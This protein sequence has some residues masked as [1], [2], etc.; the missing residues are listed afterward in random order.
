MHV[1]HSLEINIQH[2]KQQKK[3]IN[4]QLKTKIRFEKPI[5]EHRP[6][7]KQEHPSLWQSTYTIES[8]V[9]KILSIEIRPYEQFSNQLQAYIFARCSLMCSRRKS[10]RNRFLNSNK[11]F[12]IGSVVNAISP[13]KLQHTVCETSTRIG[14]QKYRADKLQ[15]LNEF[16]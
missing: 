6:R 5:N 1:G 14:R 3:I 2:I 13:H 9:P 12:K 7:S 4:E 16:H 11:I 10:D 8:H 15:M